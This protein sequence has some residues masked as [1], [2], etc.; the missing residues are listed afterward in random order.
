MEFPRKQLILVG[1]RVLIA[2]EEGEER[3]RVGLY[4]PATAIDS[5]QVQSGLIDGKTVWRSFEE[6]DTSDP[7]DGLADDYFATI[8]DEFLANGKGHRGSVGAA[9]SV[10]VQAREIVP[11]AVNWIE[12]FFRSAS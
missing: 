4:L 5:Q 9:S 11:F 1:D 3:T 2:P 8:V 7:P 6:F 10:L 12:S